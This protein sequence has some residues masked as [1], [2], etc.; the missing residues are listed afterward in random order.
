MRY[1]YDQIHSRVPAA[2][3]ASDDATQVVMPSVPGPA[4]PGRSAAGWGGTTVALHS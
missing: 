3:E 1:S 4:A 2:G